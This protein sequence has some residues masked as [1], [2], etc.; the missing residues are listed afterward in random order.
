MR[1]GALTLDGLPDPVPGPGQVTAEVLACG[2][3][4]SDLHTLD[5]TDEFSA[6]SRTAATITELPAEV[7]DPSA[8]VVMGHEF[9]ARVI[10]VGQNVANT[11]VGDVVVSIPIVMDAAGVH[12][13]GYS[14]IY[15]GAYSETIVLSDILCLKVPNGLAPHE[16][17]LTEPMAVGLHAVEMSRITPRH[18]AVVLGA[19][20][21]GLATI[22]ALRLAGVET[23]VAAD[24]SPTR[25]SLASTMGAG[26]VVDPREEPAL[27]AWRRVAGRRDLVIFEAVGIPGMIDTATNAA[28]R[29]ARVVV[30]GVCMQSD[31]IH[32]MAAVVRELNYQF[33]LGYDPEQFARTLRRISEG[34]IDVTPMITGTVS[35][36]GVADAFDELRDPE[37]HA[38][39]LVVP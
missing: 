1:A 12:P 35:L 36:D 24:L 7:F 30:A 23:I 2:I 21:V 10:E 9:C 14:S 29:G 26:E 34:E 6:M 37:R 19:G 20:P 16:A 39:V 31:T 33:V 8:D 28:P 4:G 11:S 3:C 38:K 17:A 15:P 5:H 13:V 27:E 32:P 18:D 25:R 22:A